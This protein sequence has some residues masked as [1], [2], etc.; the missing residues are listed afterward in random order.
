MPHHS[1]KMAVVE[2]FEMDRDLSPVEKFQ[3][4]VIPD[5]DVIL[6]GS[7]IGRR[8]KSYLIACESEDKSPQ[9]VLTY[10]DSLVAF[11]DY[12]K[13]NGL[14]I[15]VDRITTDDCRLYLLWLKD[16]GLAPATRSRLY[17]VLNTFFNWME[18]Q[19]YIENNS[20]RKVRPPRV[21]EV[22]VQPFTTEQLKAM[23]SLTWRSLIITLRNRAIILVFLDRGLRLNE[24]SGFR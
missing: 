2:P 18:E 3:S 24:L 16:K 7:D 22:L 15:V 21:P 23:L 11:I 14:P 9:T 13:A 6:A 4:R 19:G 10:R 12:L 8:L 20:M 5:R 1:L 17:R